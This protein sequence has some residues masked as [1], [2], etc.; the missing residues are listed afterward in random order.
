MQVF[1][2]KTN[3]DKR[4]EIYHLVIN[5]IDY[6][7]SFTKKGFGRGGDIHDCEQHNLCLKGEFNVKVLL[8]SDKTREHEIERCL[9][10]G[11]SISIPKELPHIFKALEDSIMLEWHDGK[12]PPFSEKK[13]Y[14]RYRREVM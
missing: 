12:L 1:V 2:E 11:E 6:W 8:P 7:L 14:E 4:G 5:N 9:V 3:E 13:Y 10:A